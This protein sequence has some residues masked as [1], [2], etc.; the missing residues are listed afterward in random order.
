MSP[1]TTDFSREAIEAALKGD[2]RGGEGVDATPATKRGGGGT[3]GGE[4]LVATL[5]VS[6]VVVG[7]LPRLLAAAPSA[8]I[9]DSFDFKGEGA[10]A[11][12]ADESGRFS[13]ARGPDEDEDS[14]R[15][16]NSLP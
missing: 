2:I 7:V 12:S 5:P 15:V 11:F 10:I 1:L 4:N 9:V 16:L 13:A 14:L 6:E 8:A 3:R